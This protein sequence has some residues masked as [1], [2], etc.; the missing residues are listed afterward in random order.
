MPNAAT[1]YAMLYHAQSFPDILDNDGA[2]SGG[3]EGTAV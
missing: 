3:D 2:D 1:P